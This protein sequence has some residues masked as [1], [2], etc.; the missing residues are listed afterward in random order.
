MAEE[1]GRLQSM[2]LKR[3][4]YD[5]ATKR[6]DNNSVSWDFLVAQGLRFHDPSA[7]GTGSIP[8]WVTK[9]LH[10]GRC[11]QK[12]KKSVSLYTCSRF[13]VRLKSKEGS[14]FV[15]GKLSKFLHTLAFKKK[16][17]NDEKGDKCWSDKDQEHIHH[18][19]SILETSYDSTVPKSIFLKPISKSKQQKG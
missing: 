14:Y 17:R 6:S 2:G 12:K 15:V 11:G 18:C 5:W 9:I 8:G 3:V 13:L 7:W 16:H 19:P 4:G 10:V 1:P